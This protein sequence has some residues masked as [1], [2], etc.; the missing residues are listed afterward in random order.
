[1]GELIS[2]PSVPDVENVMSFIATCISQLAGGRCDDFTRH[3]CSCWL[4]EFLVEHSNTENNVPAA[5]GNDS[6]KFGGTMKNLKSFLESMGG[7]HDSVVRQLIWMPD[8][9][10]LRVDVFYLCSNFEGL[11]E[12]PGEISGAIE[13]REIG[14]IKFATFP[15]S[16]CGI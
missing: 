1:L 12:Y 7:L 13:L 3:K 2:L 6:C 9:R 11:P 10:I 8:A 15:Q 14:R 5:L 16:A 4:A